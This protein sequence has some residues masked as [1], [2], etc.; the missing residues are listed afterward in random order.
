ML[1]Y[2]HGLVVYYQLHNNARIRSRFRQEKNLF[3]AYDVWLIM[4][5]GITMKTVAETVV[6]ISFFS[7]LTCLGEVRYALYVKDGPEG[8]S[9]ASDGGVAGTTGQSRK[10]D[11]FGISGF[12]FPTEFRIH[13][14]RDGWHKWI[15]AGAGAYDGGVG[16]RLE[17][18][19]FQF[20]QGIPADT[21]IMARVHLQD[22][23]WTP[24]VPVQD[25]T[26]LGTTGE[27]R[28]LEAIQVAVGSDEAQ[29][30]QL[31]ADRLEAFEKG[32]VNHIA[33]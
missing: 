23:G 26:V 1:R 15:A 14:E 31:L 8:W 2:R 18:I 25:Q 16:K 24:I 7:L 10:T 29:I 5:A 20:P 4:K 13:V 9:E 19:Q 21:K 30:Q 22:I 17:A 28:R 27:S 32:C 11:A 6:L 3:T 12:A 33:P